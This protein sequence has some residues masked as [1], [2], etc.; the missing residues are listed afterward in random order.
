MLAIRHP[1]QA[2]PPRARKA[3]ESAVATA[4]LGERHPLTVALTRCDSVL[5]HLCVLVLVHAAGL[6]LWW[7]S[8]EVGV[9]LVAGAVV[10]E[11]GLS[12]WWLLLVQERRG[13]CL[14]LIAAGEEALPLIALARERERLNSPRHQ[15]ELARSIARLIT[16]ASVS[17]FT[18]TARA[19]IHPR[20]LRESAAELDEIQRQ[21]EAG[22][23]SARAVALVEQL[24]SSPT[25]PLYGTD[26]GELKRQ[27]GRV[28]YLASQRGMPD[29]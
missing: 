17:D 21:M 23:V 24:L 27:L 20:V 1:Q 11:L 7:R 22:D 18:R 6:V 15:A 19:P 2:H 16:R 8:P 25:S 12:G 26:A 29:A 5:V 4:L 28:R 10:A 9:P 13:A 3:S 14:G